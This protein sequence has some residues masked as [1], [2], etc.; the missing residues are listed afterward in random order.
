MFSKVLCM[1]AQEGISTIITAIMNSHKIFR[2]LE[3]Y[4]IYRIASSLLILGY[5]F[6]AIII[7]DLEMPTWVLVLINLLNDVSAMATSLDKVSS[8]H[9]QSASQL[10]RG[11]LALSVLR[12]V[13]CSNR[14]HSTCFTMLHTFHRCYRCESSIKNSK[15]AFDYR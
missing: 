1:Y 6:F 8:C 10:C 3:T 11:L 7:F 5:F 15:L 9:G 4:V 14:I 2:R 13:L 12:R